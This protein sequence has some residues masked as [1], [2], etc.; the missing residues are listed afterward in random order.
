M[1]EVTKSLSE[2]LEWIKQ[3]MVIKMK[4]WALD[5]SLEGLKGQVTLLEEGKRIVIKCDNET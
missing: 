5:E 2:S 4:R 1:K 3:G